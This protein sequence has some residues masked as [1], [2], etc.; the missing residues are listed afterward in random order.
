MEQ[1][2]VGGEGLQVERPGDV[3][4][5]EQAVRVVDRQRRRPGR[6][7]VRVEERERLLR[8]ELD[9]AEE[10]VS[11][12]GHCRKVG[13]AERAQHPDAGVLAAVQGGCQ[14]L[15]DLGADTGRAAG[16]GVGE[17]DHRRPHDLRRR[18]RPGSDKVVGDQGAV[19]VPRLLGGDGD[20]LPRA[21]AGR[22]PVDGIAS[23]QHAYDER[24]RLAHALDGVGR[25][26]RPARRRAP[27]RRPR[28]S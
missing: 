4:G 11:E 18:V 12:I 14:T 19:E 5:F 25:E 27:P 2:Q 7:R 28:R 26:L 16:E 10:A 23:L 15:G 8:L 24:P 20:L 22:H 13:L 3:H 21:H 9:L 1:R 17:P 6:E